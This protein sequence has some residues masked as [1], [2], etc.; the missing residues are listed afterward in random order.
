M[1][2]KLNRILVVVVLITLAPLATF[3][4]PLAQEVTSAAEVYT[5]QASTAKKKEFSFGKVEFPGDTVSVTG[6]LEYTNLDA[7]D[8]TNFFVTL[9]REEGPDITPLTIWIIP[10]V[11]TP[12]LNLYPPFSTIGNGRIEKLERGESESVHFLIDNGPEG[13]N[14]ATYSLLC[15]IQWDEHEPSVLPGVFRVP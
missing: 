6:A 13:A 4:A 15:V 11:D 8:R 3:A 1:N 14:P 9:T 12:A 7:G 10:L 5:I 2:E